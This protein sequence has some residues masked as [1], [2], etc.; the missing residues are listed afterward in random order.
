MEERHFEDLTPVNQLDFNSANPAHGHIGIVPMLRQDI[1]VPS[2]LSSECHSLKNGF[3]ILS[4]PRT[5]IDF[6]V[7]FVNHT[8]SPRL[9][10]TANGRRHEEFNIRLE[11]IA[12]T[13]LAFKTLLLLTR[14]VVRRMRQ[15]EFFPSV[16]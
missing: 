1:I 16:N 3:L 6:V 4:H 8:D 13:N 7:G 12:A 10:L 14:L 5:V 9:T 2:S 11:S 15:N